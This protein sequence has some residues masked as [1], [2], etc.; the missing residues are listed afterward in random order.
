MDTTARKRRF[1]ETNPTHAFADHPSA[2]LAH[3][4]SEVSHETR[5]R[6]DRFRYIGNFGTTSKTSSPASTTHTEPAAKRSREATSE[7]IASSTAREGSTSTPTTARF[8]LPGLAPPS[9]PKRPSNRLAFEP[10]EPLSSFQARMS[11]N[12]SRSSFVSSNSHDNRDGREKV[13]LGAAVRSVK[14]ILSTRFGGSA[15]K[16]R[17]LGK[18]VPLVVPREKAAQDEEEESAEARLRRLYRS[19]DG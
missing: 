18:G 5:A 10:A 13:L 12:N 6:L 4:S 1:A 9:A 14:P 7:S 15:G 3:S 17:K 19:L 11:S 8:T 2:G 16:K